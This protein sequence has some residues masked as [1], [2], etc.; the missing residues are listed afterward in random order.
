M[1]RHRSQASADLVGTS[2]VARVTADL[3]HQSQRALAKD[4][5]TLRTVPAVAPVTIRSPTPRR[6][7]VGWTAASLP[8]LIPIGYGGS[9]QFAQTADSVEVD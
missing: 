1:Y 9:A 3:H 6:S 7:C 5:S 4:G 8:V 2:S